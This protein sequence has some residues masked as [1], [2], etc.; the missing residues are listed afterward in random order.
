[1]GI[2]DYRLA[3]LLG[4]VVIAGFLGGWSM[5]WVTILR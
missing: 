1:M 3:T 2:A 5:G 4:L